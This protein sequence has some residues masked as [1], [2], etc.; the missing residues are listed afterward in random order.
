MNGDAKRI[1][2]SGDSAGGNLA[3]AVAMV[4]RDRGGPQIVAQLLMYPTL[5]NKMD[6]ASWNAFGATNFPTRAVQTQVLKAYVPAGISPYAPLVAP[7]WGDHRKLP[8]ALI[9]VG[10]EDPLRDEALDYSGELNKNGIEAKTVVYPGNHHG[11]VQYFKDK[12]HH[13]LGEAALDD[14]SA[15]LRE[16]LG[17][18]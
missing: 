3:A 12:E 2:V 17:T 13:P 14:G 7:L 11:F 10:G 18:E 4:A 6:T 16:K 1:A 15:F 9:V 8:S 5:S